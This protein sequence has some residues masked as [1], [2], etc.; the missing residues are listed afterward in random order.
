[1]IIIRKQFSAAPGVAEEVAKKLVRKAERKVLNN[2]EKTFNEGAEDAGVALGASG[3]AAGVGY[4]CSKVAE[5]AEK[6]AE[7]LSDKLRWKRNL[8]KEGKKKVEVENLE[9]RSEF[10]RNLADKVDKVGKAVTKFSKKKGAK[11]AMI[12]TPALIAG[13]TS[14]IVRKNKRKKRSKHDNTENA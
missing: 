9:P 12:A 11:A 4:V 1:M 3:L 6:H 7:D 14:Y 8:I 13:G 10:S 2:D 5:N